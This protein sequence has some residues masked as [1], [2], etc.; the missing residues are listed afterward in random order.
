MP[1]IAVER[2]LGTPSITI[3]HVRCA[4]GCKHESEAECASATHIVFP[5]R[6]VYV[7]H[8]GQSLS[9]A[10]ANQVLFFNSGQ[11][12][13]VSHPVEGGDDCLSL[14]VADEVLHE[15]APAAML[16]PGGAARFLQQHQ[17][18]GP[19]V[20][21]QLAEL[22]RTLHAGGDP[23]EAETRTMALLRG[24]I[25]GVP[26]KSTSH[27]KRKLA[28]RIKLLL[29]SD[30]ARRWTLAGIAEQ[31]GGSPVYLTQAFQQAEGMPLY[32]YQLQ[33]RLARALALMDDYDDLSALSFDL[34]FS[35]HSHFSASFRQLYGRAP[36][37]VRAS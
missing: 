25:G 36:S 28:E 18:I 22:L 11:E 3:S 7:R 35:S 14:F 17:R 10:D 2:L 21:I 24:A 5:Y 12:Y 30:P 19:D 23:L 32:R 15:L 9:V 16:Q 29:A 27:A 37:A 8:V 31:V 33:L 6:G 26:H 20:Q 34:G 4:G 13:S 1:E